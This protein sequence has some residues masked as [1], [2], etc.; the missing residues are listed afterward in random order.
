MPANASLCSKIPLLPPAEALSRG[1]EVSNSKK[2]DMVLDVV[3][4][5]TERGAREDRISIFQSLDV[6]T[7]SM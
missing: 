6:M 7:P 5:R 4:R 3:T 2:D 1:K